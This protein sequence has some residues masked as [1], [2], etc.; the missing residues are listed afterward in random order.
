MPDQDFPMQPGF[1]QFVYNI[2]MQMETLYWELST[3]II[4][5]N[6]FMFAGQ[7]VGC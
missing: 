2:S 5:M 6:V 3:Y 7:G 1:L 4:K